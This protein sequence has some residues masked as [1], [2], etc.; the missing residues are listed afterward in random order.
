M[1]ALET[2]LFL[3]IPALCRANVIGIDFGSENMKIGIVS[4]GSPLEIGL[5]ALPIIGIR[6]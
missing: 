2:F 6:G 4:P 5:M 1:I 3:V